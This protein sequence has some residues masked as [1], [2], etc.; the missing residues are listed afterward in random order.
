MKN[1]TMAKTVKKKAS[2]KRASNYEPK[3]KFAGRFE[4]MINISIT[5]AGAKKVTQKDKK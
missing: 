2:K 3:V 4:D 5:G 1:V